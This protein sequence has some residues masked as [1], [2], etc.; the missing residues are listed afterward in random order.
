MEKIRK[1]NQVCF[2]PEQEVGRLFYCSAPLPVH[3]CNA[4]LQR[5]TIA[6]AVVDAP[7]SWPPV[8]CPH[9]PFDFPAPNRCR[10]ARTMPNLNKP[11]NAKTCV[12]VY[13]VLC[14]K[15]TINTNTHT[16]DVNRTWFEVDIVLFNLDAVLRFPDQSGPFQVPA[17]IGV[18]H[19]CRAWSVAAT[20]ATEIET[21]QFAVLAVGPPGVGGSGAGAHAIAPV[22]RNV[23]LVFLLFL[24]KRGNLKEKNGKKFCQK[25]VK[26]TIR[27][28]ESIDW[29]ID[30]LIFSRD[31]ELQIEK[32]NMPNFLILITFSIN[33]IISLLNVSVIKFFSQRKHHVHQKHY[34]K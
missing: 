16:S 12:Q 32:L 7:A 29:L 18:Q 33:T 13:A 24:E 8:L 23:Q 27:F 28:L 3:C 34:W 4:P 17:L 1:L 9:C 15:N 5:W 2:L 30:W 21:G 26:I 6:W 22:Q 19:G 20:A 25:R 31:L 14:R 11:H 10:A